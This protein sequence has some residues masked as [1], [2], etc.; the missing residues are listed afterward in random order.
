MP[1][2]MNDT[3]SVRPSPSSMTGEYFARSSGVYAG[4]VCVD[5]SRG[6]EPTLS[7]RSGFSSGIEKLY[8]AP[9]TWKA[10]DTESA[11]ALRN[12]TSAGR[13][14]SIRN[15]AADVAGE[16]L[17]GASGLALMFVYQ[18]P[19]PPPAMLFR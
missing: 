13:L 5:G 1:R 9:R 10:W 8:F 14:A 3:W 11:V 4:T 15:Q 19:T 7:S 6:V 17:F 2:L 18:G 12:A 16:M